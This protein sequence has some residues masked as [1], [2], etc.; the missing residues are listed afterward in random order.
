[1]AGLSTRTAAL[2]SRLLIILITSPAARRYPRISTQANSHSGGSHCYDL[3]IAPQLRGPP[4]PFRI[5]QDRGAHENICVDRDLQW[6]PARPSAAISVISSIV[7]R[8]VPG[9]YPQPMKLW[10]DPPDF[11]ARSSRRPFG[12]DLSRP[13][14]RG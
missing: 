4:C 7:S 1:M 12:S 13:S 10:I 8:W 6:R 9:R 2:S 5:I 3:R 11:A 14:G